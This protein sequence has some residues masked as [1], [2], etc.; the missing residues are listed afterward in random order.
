MKRKYFLVSMFLLL[1]FFVLLQRQAY[2][3]GA[4]TN[5]NFMMS[6]GQVLGSNDDVYTYIIK[7]ATYNSKKK[8]TPTPTLSSVNDFFPTLTPLPTSTPRPTSTPTP[9]AT[10]TPTP[11]PTPRPSLT[12]YPT[13]YISP[14]IPRATSTPRIMPTATL[15]PTATPTVIK[16]YRPTWWPTATP[17]FPSPTSAP[18]SSSSSSSYSS[19]ALPTQVPT[20][21]Y[22]PLSPT[23][24]PEQYRGKKSTIV[25]E[26]PQPTINPASPYT[27][28][29][30]PVT[31]ILKGEDVKTISINLPSKNTTSEGNKGSAGT[32]VANTSEKPAGAL[33]I[34]L[35]EKQGGTLAIAQQEFVIQKGVQAV[36]V[37]S[38]EQDSGALTIEQDDTK[39]RTTMSLSVNPSTNILAV[40]TP[41]GPMKVSIMPGDAMAIMRQLKVIDLQG[42]ARDILLEVRE[43]QL[44]YK[45]LADKTEKLFWVIPINVPRELYVAADTGGLIEIKKSSLYSFLSLFTF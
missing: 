11:T 31:R 6:G 35:E 30:A 15:I 40:D 29:P 28:P 36:T 34:T 26:M 7:G 4:T 41:S 12:P 42:V 39:A 43:G 17:I 23:P 44:Q 25:I 19:E 5:S 18:A 32:T 45:I 20:I 8:T 33:D 21:T 22:G 38:N 3:F 27:R 9:T 2:G 24:I 14:T 13:R 1:V 16:T 37:S 10:P